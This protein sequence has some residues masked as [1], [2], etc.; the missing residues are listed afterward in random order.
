MP[1]EL[2]RWIFNWVQG[3][4]MSVSHGNTTSTSFSISVGA[5]QGHVLTALLFRLH[6]HYLPSHFLHT[7]CH[8]FADDLIIIIKGVLEMR[9]SAN[10]KYLE[11]QARVVLKSSETFSN[12]HILPVNVSKTKAIIVHSAVDVQ[13]PV[14]KYK[15]VNIG[16]VTS[17]KCLGIEIGTKL[18]MGKNIEIRLK[19]KMH[20]VNNE[21]KKSSNQGPQH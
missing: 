12:N 11:S 20:S 18:G 16:Y 13:K 15:D 2:R 7:V 8:L 14:I 1:L 4:K 3:R 5:S 6:M 17:F 19:Y 10:I 9:L 21:Y